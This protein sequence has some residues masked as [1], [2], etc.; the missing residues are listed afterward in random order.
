MAI[1]PD[2]KDWTWVLQ[3]PCAECGFDAAAVAFSDVPALVRRNAAAWPAELQ[4]P[5][6]AQRQS[7]DRWSVLEY[8]A[9]V[10]DVFTI[11][12]ERLAL[13]REQ[14]APRFANWDQDATAEQERYAEQDP[15]VVAEQLLAAGEAA[16]DAFA[17]VP[18]E[19]LQRPGLRSDGSAFTVESLALYFLHDPVHHLHDVQR[20]S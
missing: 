11:F 5:G 14:D 18:P 13:M 15:A 7:P 17:A 4:R 16:A 6:A 10:R 19:D 3:R 12:T 8:A 9:H 1:V 2:T 20:S